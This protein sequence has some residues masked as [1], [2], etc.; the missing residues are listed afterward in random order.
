MNSIQSSGNINHYNKF[1]GK[2]PC[3]NPVIE[4]DIQAGLL[5]S[6]HARLETIKPLD[7]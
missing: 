7:K 1:K 6:H 2:I 5:K 4:L 3:Q